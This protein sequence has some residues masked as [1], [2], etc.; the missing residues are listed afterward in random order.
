MIKTRLF[1]LLP[2]S[3][4]YVAQNVV[5]QWLGLCCNIGMVFAVCRVL[6]QLYI[7]G[8]FQKGGIVCILLAALGR[9]LFA[10]LSAN[11]AFA[12]SCGVKRAL[13]GQ[14]YQKLL[15]LGSSYTGQIT[16]AEVIQLAG[17]GVEQLETYFGAYLPQLFYALLAAVT[18]FCVIAPIS[19]STA[20]ILFCCVPMIPLAIVAVQKIAK[21]LLAN[22]WGQYTQMGDH[23]LE[24]LQ[25]LTTLK[26][27]G[28][29]AQRH[30]EMNEDAE[31]FRRITMKVLTMQLNSIIIM[32][33]F[34]YGGAALG[35][36]CAVRQMQAGSVDLFGG[37]SIL[38]LSADFF[39]PMRRLGSFFHVAMNG[40][41]AADKIFH[42][43]DLEEPGGQ[44]EKAQANAPIICRD[45]CFAYEKERP[46]LQQIDLQITPGGLIA[47]A[48]VSG[49]GKSTLAAILTGRCRA[50]SGS[51]R[52]GEAELRTIREESLMKQITLVSHNS[53]LFKGTVRSNLQPAAPGAG[54]KEM[55]Q[56]LARVQ[57]ADFLRTQNGLDT[58]I[59]EGAGNLSGGQRQRLALARALLHDTPMY[60]FDEATSNIDM[61][62]ETVILNEIYRMAKEKTVL[63]ISHR[64]A[65]IQNADCIYFM[66]HGRI[67]QSGTH[68]ALLAQGGGYQILWEQQQALEQLG[69]ENAS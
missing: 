19:L 66:Q 24:N 26:I 17:E 50:Y 64:L 49:C 60:I 55:W 51:V 4:K 14:I 7:S 46:V 59:A 42:L 11:A 35:I 62:S 12:S 47:L 30:Q 21:R 20:L 15:R 23:F 63:M 48:G 16:S 1:S 68:A 53:Y 3:K 10:K 9:A 32:D 33:F 43:L 6:Q 37:L 57:L 27:Y 40:M 41:T 31:N 25:G 5:F 56:V 45:L 28:A 8:S 22:Y 36:V 54:E 44:T 18:L 2:E 67:T 52:I 69:K 61:E 29:D 65:A 39:L 34:A 38:L 58:P 13:R